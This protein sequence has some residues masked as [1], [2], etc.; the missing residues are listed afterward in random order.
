[1]NIASTIFYF[2]EAV[3]ALA[4]IGILF[5]RN[6]FYAA[7]LL[8]VTLLCVAGIYVLSFAEFIAVTQI[9]VYAGGILVLIIFG[10]MLTSRISGRPLMVS[11]K[12]WFIALPAGGF[13]FVLLTKL[14]LKQSY[15]SSDPVSA[16]RN[17]IQ[18]VGVS[19]MSDFIL[20]FEVAGI[21]LLVALI[22]AAI[23]ASFIK[24]SSE[25]VSH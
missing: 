4:A 12:Y 1:M 13:F 14:L 21:L 19:L 11:N 20:P 7:L 2:L 23:T 10:I 15:A 16:P 24:K 22:G 18:Q 5:V 6:V 25:D 9:L 17:T 8:L 3:A